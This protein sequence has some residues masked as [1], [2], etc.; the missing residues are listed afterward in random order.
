MS[1]IYQNLA[2][3]IIRTV[4]APMMF[5]SMQYLRMIQSRS[6]GIGL[7]LCLVGKF[8]DRKVTAVCAYRADSGFPVMHVAR[9]APPPHHGLPAPLSSYTSVVLLGRRRD[10]RV[11][12]SP[13]LLLS[14]F[15]HL[16]FRLPGITFDTM[17]RRGSFAWL[18]LLYSSG[19]KH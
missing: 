11:I 6:L 12:A 13:P 10:G 3:L 14:A 8:L 4:H 19:Y 2:A 9:T 5:Q 16:Q 1:G 15:A 18:S 17:F 7:F